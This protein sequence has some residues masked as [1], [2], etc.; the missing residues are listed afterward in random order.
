[1]SETNHLGR[2]VKYQ[3]AQQ[4][5]ND[6]FPFTRLAQ[7]EEETQPKERQGFFARSL[8]RKKKSNRSCE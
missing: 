4:F 6:A 8:P 3:T 1:M 2:E 5:I 7:D